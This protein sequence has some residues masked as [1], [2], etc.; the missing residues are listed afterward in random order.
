MPRGRKTKLTPELQETILKIIRAGNYAL[1]ACQAV[2]INQDTYYTWLKRGKKDLEDNKTTIYSEFSES[3]ERASAIAEASHVGNVATSAS[4]GDV[5]SSKWFL[6]RKHPERWG[7]NDKLRAEITGANGGA[8][9]IA[10]SRAAILELLNR[11]NSGVNDNVQLDESA[12][13]DNQ[14]G[15]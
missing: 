8:I 6:E 2:G 15:E 13:N 1:V 5:N 10:D 4:N 7:R 11:R 9:E 14:E 3:I 12:Q